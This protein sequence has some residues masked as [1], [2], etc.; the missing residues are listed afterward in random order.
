MYRCAQ[1]VAACLLGPPLEWTCG[2]FSEVRAMRKLAALLEAGGLAEIA[3]L[4]STAKPGY[5]EARINQELDRVP[6]AEDKER[7]FRI[8]ALK[9]AARNIRKWGIEP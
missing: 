4:C 5:V 1:R 6:Y 2:P 7:W 9:H 8:D 3:A